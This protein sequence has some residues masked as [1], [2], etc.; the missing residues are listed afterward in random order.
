M[1]KAQPVWASVLKKTGSKANPQDLA[2][3]LSRGILKNDGQ[4]A[5]E[6]LVQ[7]FEKVVAEWG[8]LPAT[9]RPSASVLVRAFRCTAAQWGSS[10]PDL[11]E[12]LLAV[13]LEHSAGDRSSRHTEGRNTRERILAAAQEVFSQK[14]FHQATMDEIAERADVGK[15]TLYRHFPSKENLFHQLVQIRLNELEAQAE[16]VL[17]SED[18]VLSMIEKYLSIYFDFFDR[19]QGLYRV[20]VHEHPDL[21]ERLQDLYVEKIMRRIPH[22]KRKIREARL[23]N[24][25]KDVN[26]QTVFHGAMGFIHGVIQRWLAQDCTYSLVKELP[27]VKEVL[28][29]G[30]VKKPKTPEE[31]MSWTS[32]K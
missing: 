21:D 17:D 27:T 24:V 5:V 9:S 15:G 20:M 32:T 11:L 18:D 22:L 4:D 3:A 1:A 26:F 6:A 8:Q 14:G 31:D 19:N 12:R 13:V 16:C 23:Q 30:F 7:T 2:H 29:Y 10:E 25:L 28:F